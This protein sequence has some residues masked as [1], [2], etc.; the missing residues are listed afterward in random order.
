MTIAL[1]FLH[2]ACVDLGNVNKTVVFRQL[3]AKP[4]LFQSLAFDEVVKRFHEVHNTCMK[5]E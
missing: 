3:A 4:K 2:E 5:C 1:T